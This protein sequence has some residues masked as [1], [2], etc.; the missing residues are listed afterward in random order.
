M[1][2]PCRALLLHWRRASSSSPRPPPR[3]GAGQMRVDRVPRPPPVAVGPRPGPQVRA[4]RTVRPPPGPGLGLAPAPTTSEGW[5]PSSRRRPGG[6]PAGAR[7]RGLADRD[8][9]TRSWSRRR[10]PGRARRGGG[11]AQ[12]PRRPSGPA[13]GPDRARPSHRGT[14][15]RDVPGHPALRAEGVAV[16]RLGREPGPLGPG[17]RGPGSP[18]LRAPRGREHRH[19]AYA[20]IGHKVVEAA[21]LR[22]RLRA[23]ALAGSTETWTT[24]ASPASGSAPSRPLRRRLLEWDVGPR[25][26]WRTRPSPPTSAGSRSRC[27]RTMGTRRS[28]ALPHADRGGG[29]ECTRFV[30]EVVASRAHQRPP[31]GR[32]VVRRPRGAPGGLRLGA[33]AG[34]WVARIAARGIGPPRDRGAEPGALAERRAW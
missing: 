3:G 2:R 31:A 6:D 15:A 7:R 28:V 22:L 29:H 34:L 18:R 24:C 14:L 11:G 8:G 1:A 21:G 25:C 27:R 9:Q 20:S 33:K 13:Q 17:G 30:E 4:R 16:G 12:G 19:P 26:A 10:R 5:P 23:A 32:L